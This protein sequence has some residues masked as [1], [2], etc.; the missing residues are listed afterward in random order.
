MSGV[1]DEPGAVASGGS[2]SHRAATEILARRKRWLERDTTVDTSA[3]GHAPARYA[4][5]GMVLL[6]TTVVLGGETLTTL[7]RPTT[8]VI[9]GA[10]ALA[11]FCASLMSILGPAQYGDL[12]I[13]RWKFGPWILLWCGGAFGVATTTWSHPQNGTPAQIAITSVLKALWL[14]AVGM[15]AWALGYVVGVG[16]S[17]R[18]FGTRSLEMMTARFDTEVRSRSAPWLLYAIGI[19]A[20]LAITA[21]SGFLGYVGNPSSLASSASGYSGILG[22]LS[23]C[24]PLAVAAASLQVFRERLA[25]ARLTL[26]ILFLMEVVFGA[27]SGGKESFVIA[28]LAVIVP[29]S[30]SR[31]RLPKTVIIGSV[32]AFLVVVIPFNQAYRSVVRGGS[33]TLTPREAVAAA[34]GILRQTV[35]HGVVTVMPTSFAYLMQRIRQIDSPAIILQ[36]TPGQIRFLSPIRLAEESV[37]GM[38]PRVVWPG[39]PISLTGYQFS[40]DYF[41]LPPTVY[42]STA[43]TLIGGFYIYGGWIPV[44]AGMFVVGCG[45]RFL[46]DILDIRANPHAIFLVLLLFSSLVEGQVDWQ[47][48]LTSV[49]AITAVWL[50]AV[51][52]TFRARARA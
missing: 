16:Q 2:A 31:R 33:A 17:I 18:R 4:V 37:S 43:D 22:A 52:A 27:A 8:A 25:G 50:L 26:A 21:T 24:A 6:S 1:M 47:A 13:A 51:A 35:S 32:I 36:R 41:G 29:F 48:I 46:D 23:L 7:D 49:P 5:W 12:G 44:I 11:A 30:A 20:R 28:V 10:L 34:P 19:S 45:I 39:K 14:I 38:V 3:L 40:Q 9:W 15:G 42:T